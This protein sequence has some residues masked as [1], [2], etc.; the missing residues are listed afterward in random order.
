MVLGACGDQSE[1][2]N[3]V[4][5]MRD[6]YAKMTGITPILYV[7][8]DETRENELDKVRRVGAL[9]FSDL[10]ASSAPPAEFVKI[11]GHLGTFLVGESSKNAHADK[12]LCGEIL[13]CT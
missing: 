6:Q 2:L 10:V 13:E 12:Y 9:L 7:A 11:P 8:T 4:N 1:W 5:R 3:H